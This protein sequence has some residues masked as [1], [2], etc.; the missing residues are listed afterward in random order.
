MALSAPAEIIS[1]RLKSPPPQIGRRILAH[2]EFLVGEG[3]CGGWAQCPGLERLVGRERREPAPFK[4]VL[5]GAR[6]FRPV[7]GRDAWLV[8]LGGVFV[9]FIFFWSPKGSVSAVR[10][11]AIVRIPF[12]TGLVPL[13]NQ[14]F[15]G[16][17]CALCVFCFVLHNLGLAPLNTHKAYDA[18][19]AQ[20]VE[21]SP[22][23][24][25]FRHTRRA[26]GVENHDPHGHTPRTSSWRA[27]FPPPTLLSL[28]HAVLTR[29]TP[30]ADP[31]SLTSHSYTHPITHKTPN[32][33]PA[34][35]QD[36]MQDHTSLP[37][38]HSCIPQTLVSS[39]GL[40]IRKRNEIDLFWVLSFTLGVVKVLPHQCCYF[41]WTEWL[42][43]WDFRSFCILKQSLKLTSWT[44][45]SYLY[46][47][48]LVFASPKVF[49]FNV[50]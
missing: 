32:L 46:Y 31:Q 48:V 5:D 40:C 37:A 29:E 34:A 2:W 3:D 1:S 12:T 38:T 30:R 36:T 33:P 35:T 24:F 44:N 27:Q 11:E 43:D 15:W 23:P 20:H 26:Q 21:H 50:V 39:S 18:Q 42:G 6:P 25:K 14:S 7:W 8:G 19:S 9:C 13:S 17:R 10:G 16:R 22:A 28:H 47:F 49:F 41:C 45:L 4:R